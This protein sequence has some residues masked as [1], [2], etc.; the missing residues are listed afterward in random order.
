M[1][2]SL[3]YPYNP[4]NNEALKMF[5]G[6]Y[7]GLARRWVVPNNEASQ[8][9]IEELFGV[10]LPNVIAFVTE[11]NL[12]ASGNLVAL[13]GYLVASWDDRKNCV[14]LPD[15]V[16]LVQ[17]SWDTTASATLKQPRLAGVAPAVHVVVKRDFAVTHGLGIVEELVGQVPKNPLAPFP[18]SDLQ[19]EL[20]NRGY[21]VVRILF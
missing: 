19:T 8:K 9:K 18:D 3:R 20:E 10:A 12:T 13:G 4:N 6:R 14:R 21:G 5:G 15:G 2:I 1:G 7:D 16:E 11:K 17:G